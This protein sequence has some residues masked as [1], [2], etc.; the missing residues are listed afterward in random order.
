MALESF[1]RGLHLLYFSDELPCADVPYLDD[2]LLCVQGAEGL[3]VVRR[4][5]VFH[6]SVLLIDRLELELALLAVLS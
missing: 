4:T 3:D 5:S 1:E 6:Q 2:I